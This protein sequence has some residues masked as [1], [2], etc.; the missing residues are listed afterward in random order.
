MK[1]NI[2]KKVSLSL[3]LIFAVAG[4]MTTVTISSASAKN[5]TPT[6][7]R[8]TW[9]HKTKTGKQSKLVIGEH[10]VRGKRVDIVRN[11]KIKIKGTH[12]KKQ[13]VIITGLYTDKRLYKVILVPTKMKIAGKYRNVLLEL[14]QWTKV[15]QPFVWLVWTPYKSSASLFGKKITVYGSFGF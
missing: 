14:A 8:N 6:N 10:S 4:F 2:L 15:D 1:R 13:P 7:S 3:G 9:Y 12:I 11:I 5:E